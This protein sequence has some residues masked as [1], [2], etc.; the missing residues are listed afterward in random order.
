MRIYKHLLVLIGFII[1]IL[2]STAQAQ[3]QGLDVKQFG[4]KGDGSTDDTKA[5]RAAFASIAKTGGTIYFP[6]GTYL[7]DV[8]D[9][10]PEQGKTVTVIGDGPASVVKIGSSFVNPVAVFFCEIPG[11]NLSFK[12][13]TINGNYMNRPKTWKTGA[14]GLI[15]VDHPL[16]GIFGYNLNALTVTNCT[17]EQV[18]GDAIASYSANRLEAN[19]NTI[20]NVSG[21]GI[22]GHRVV[23]MEVNHNKISNCGLITSSYILDGKSQT[24]SDATAMTQF[25]DGIEAE[26]QDLKATFNTIL[27]AGRCGIVQDLAKDLKYMASTAIVSNNTIT[28]N[29]SR[30][31]NSNP[32]SGMWFEQSAK[33]TV[34]NNTI[35]L[36]RSKSKITSGIRF[37]DVTDVITCSGNHISASNYNHVS[38]NGIGVIEPSAALV[39]ITN[40]IIKGKFK[41]GIAVSYQQNGAKL[42][43]LR[44]S[45][46]SM[47]GDKQIERGI[48]VGVGGKAKF[49]DK[50]DITANSLS[51]IRIKP[52]E[53][54]YFGEGNNKSYVS[55]LNISGNKLDAAFTHYKMVM[56]MGLVVKKSKWY[57]KGYL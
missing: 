21:S 37:F 36:I 6:P 46:N 13:L 40:N 44:I 35:D 45:Q 50:T 32:P 15:N 4:A 51:G 52:Y 41:S 9:I 27:N 22:K 12:N 11:V 54:T 48:L 29:S 5:L 8:V 28:A 10:R 26:C 18:H 3:M 16:H 17:I 25:G 33:V 2:F 34:T 55:A 38:D 43:N 24:L 20:N 19:Y 53:F 42:R 57:Q 1:I 47:E 23:L 49:P 31:N 56:P 39:S 7:T 30:I 14:T